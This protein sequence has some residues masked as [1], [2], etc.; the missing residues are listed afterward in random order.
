MTNE[1]IYVFT[2]DYMSFKKC[3]ELCSHLNV[4]KSESSEEFVV[5]EYI[6]D[7]DIDNRIVCGKVTVQDWANLNLEKHNF[8]KLVKLENK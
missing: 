6:D 7:L 4:L 1:L 3:Q 8:L 2:R 5:N